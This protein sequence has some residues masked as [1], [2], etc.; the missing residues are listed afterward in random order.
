MQIKEQINHEKQNKEL[1]KFD[2]PLLKVLSIGL[3]FTIFLSALS[4]SAGLIFQFQPTTTFAKIIFYIVVSLFTILWALYIDGTSSKCIE[5]V[6]NSIQTK[7]FWIEKK[8]KIRS[9]SLVLILSTCCFFL[10][11]LS[12]VL[13]KTSAE[14]AAVFFAK[15]EIRKDASLEADKKEEQKKQCLSYF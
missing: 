15:S 14:K 2:S 1:Y 7:E 9:A 11:W 4:V 13:S 5:W 12:L 6:T 8:E 10:T 3:Y